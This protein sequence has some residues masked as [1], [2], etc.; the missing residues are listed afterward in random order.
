MPL[1][2][3]SVAYMTI[4]GLVLYSGIKGS[5]LTDTVK[6]ALAGNLGTLQDTQQP[7][8][9]IVIQGTQQS[10]TGT[11]SGPIQG[12]VNPGTISHGAAQNQELAKKIAISRGLQSWTTGQIWQD[13]VQ[14]W[15]MESGW[16]E[17]AANPT[18]DARGIAQKITGW[19]SDYQQGN[20]YQQ[21]VWGINYILGRYG[22]PSMALAHELSTNPHWY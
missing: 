9:P 18:S 16:N 6:A 19:S 2:G 12:T 22:N 1:T 21:I 17:N 7:G 10:S 20:S 14:L 13:W 15:N 11:Q 3:A 4:G 5:T 8:T